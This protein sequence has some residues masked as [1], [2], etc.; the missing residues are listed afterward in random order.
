M[1]GIFDVPIIFPKHADS[2][3]Y[4]MKYP[5]KKTLK[6]VLKVI[7][8]FHKVF[9]LLG[10]YKIVTNFHY[11]LLQRKFF[12]VNIVKHRL[13]FIRLVHIISYIGLETHG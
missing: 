10:T 2:I 11:C 7:A 3:L 12:L 13:V 6:V 8:R 4:T 5:F 9:G 1:F